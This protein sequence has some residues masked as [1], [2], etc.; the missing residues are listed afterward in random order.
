M[1]Q[2]VKKEWSHFVWSDVWNTKTQA[3]LCRTEPKSLR[4]SLRCKWAPLFTFYHDVSYN[5]KP[6]SYYLFSNHFIKHCFN[7]QLVCCLELLS[8]RAN[9]NSYS[10]LLRHFLKQHIIKKLLCVLRV[11]SVITVTENRISAKRAQTKNTLVN[12]LTLRL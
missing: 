9:Q 10:S 3:K 7:R 2:N 11:L 5:W 8:I 6:F 4:I 1:I 12:S